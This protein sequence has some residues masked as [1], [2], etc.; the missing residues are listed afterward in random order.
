MRTGSLSIFF[1]SIEDEI[2]DVGDFEQPSDLEAVRKLVIKKLIA[3]G[4]TPESAREYFF[5]Y[6]EDE[7]RDYLDMLGNVEEA[8]QSIFAGIMDPDRI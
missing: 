2:G 6:P 3:Y 8:A 5:Q 7:I 4:E 1:E